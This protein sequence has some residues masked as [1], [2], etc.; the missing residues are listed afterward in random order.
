MAADAKELF[1]VADSSDR[2]TMKK[3]SL[4][5]LGSGLGRA[6][7]M[8]ARIMQSEGNGGSCV[9][10]DGEEEIVDLLKKNCDHNGVFERSRRPR[11]EDLVED[12]LLVDVGCVCQPLWWGDRASLDT[13]LTTYP[14]GFDIIIGI[15]IVCLGILHVIKNQAIIGFIVCRCRSYIRTSCWQASCCADVHCR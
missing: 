2:T 8:A 1:G 5:E 9:L 10:T 14:G 12:S 3:C 6:G 15:I 13:L 4:L 7:I 11:A